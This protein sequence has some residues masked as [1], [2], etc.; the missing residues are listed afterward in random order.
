MKNSTFSNVRRAMMGSAMGLTLLSVACGSVGDE[1]NFRLQDQS[2]NHDKSLRAISEGRTVTYHVLRGNLL[3]SSVN[4]DAA[5]S[6]NDGVFTIASFENNRVDVTGVSAGS[7][8]IYLD[9]GDKSDNFELE[10]RQEAGALYRVNEGDTYYTRV[11]EHASL[12]LPFNANMRLTHQ[13]FL[14]QQGRGLSGT[15]GSIAWTGIDGTNVTIGS[16]DSGYSLT[17]ATGSEP[18]TGQASSPWSSTPLRVKATA[19]AEASELRAFSSSTLG[20]ATLDGRTA[21]FTA[22]ALASVTLDVLDSEGFAHVGDWDLDAKV[23]LSEN[24]AGRVNIE[25]AECAVEIEGAGCQVYEDV[26]VIRLLVIA[27]DTD[28]EIDVK[29][30]VGGLVEDWKFIFTGRD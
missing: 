16:A 7:A 9:A 22:G 5:T 21:T 1:G 3:G 23:S 6:S 4:L 30:E 28:Q 26:D 13:N 11:R 19:D 12:R 27:S 2:E 29:I 8:R 14:D 20:S 25:G 17:I 24:G 18:G 15:G 10:V